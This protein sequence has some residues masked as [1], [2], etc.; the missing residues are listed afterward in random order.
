MKYFLEI[1]NRKTLLLLDEFGTGSDP[2][3]GG[4]LAEVFFE[5]L[6]NKKC[7]GVITT[8]YASIKLKADRLK[9]AING[10]MLFNT[11]TLE[12][13][14]RFSIGQP[15]SSFTFEVAQING[16]PQELIEDA[17]T[18]VNEHKV[19]MDKLLSELQRE[20]TY[21][22]KLNNEHIEAQLVASKSKIYFDEQKAKYDEKLKALNELSLKNNT[23]I[24]YGKK[25]EQFI[26]RFVT[27]SRKKD[28]NS[29]LFEDIKKFISVEKSKEEDAKKI[30]TFKANINLP[31]KTS[32]KANTPPK[33]NKDPFQQ[34][35]I[36]VGSLVKLIET[37]QTGTVEEIQNEMC[38]VSF[39]FLKM[40][41]NKEKLMWVK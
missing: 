4:A 29:I 37:K 11:D 23:Y 10:C 40:K 15:G 2:D 6:Y 35:K 22:E 19:N 13:L 31:P 5:H 25:F 34:S 24:L 21:L 8:H 12:P 41:V 36:K 17:K 33:E 3:L 16:I 14:Y 20:K 7:F 38:T 27:K 18:K 32:K 28:I 30:V 1:S 39:G 26:K 9:N